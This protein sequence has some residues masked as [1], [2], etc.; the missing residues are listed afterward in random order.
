MPAAVATALSSLPGFGRLMLAT[1]RVT[2]VAT[3]PSPKTRTLNFVI[4]P[5]TGE[6]PE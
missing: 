6:P 4:T 3:P 5:S 1:R 2:L